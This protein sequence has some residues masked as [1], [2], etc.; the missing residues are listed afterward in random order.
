M[1]DTV[2]FGFQP[3]NQQ[4]HRAAVKDVF[5]TVAPHYDCMNDIMSLGLHRL[6]KR[7]LVWLA[8]ARSTERWLDLATGSGDIAALLLAGTARPQVVAT[9][10]SPPMLERARRRLRSTPQATFVH[11]PAE[12]LP[13]ATA[14]FDGATCAFG[15]RNF[16]DRRASL[17][18]IHRVLR[19]G[20][21]LLVLEFSRPWPVLGAA[22]RNYLL[23][24][25]PA[26]G[27]RLAGTAASYRYLAESILAFPDQQQL[28][29][30][31]ALAGFANVRWF[32]LTT[33]IVAIHR[34]WKLL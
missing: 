1:T 3:A 17:Q 11:C 28:A 6:W 23:N 9:D 26:L 33:G 16:T 10:P 14:S 31:C 20:G 21:R 19:P 25:L 32:N 5:T 15:L 18:E 27:A 7:Q 8:A 34:C 22:H 2:S 12:Q 30:L 13:F 24:V 4:A 29:D